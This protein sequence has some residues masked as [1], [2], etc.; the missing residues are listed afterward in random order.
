MLEGDKPLGLA[1][2]IALL[3][4]VRRVCPAAEVIDTSAARDENG[5][6]LSTV[7]LDLTIQSRNE[8]ARST[9]TPCFSIMS[10]KPQQI[11]R[12]A[13]KIIG[14]APVLSNSTP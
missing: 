10:S 13:Q 2:E 4:F 12:F 14:S 6:R 5:R 9:G 3:M 1:S 11:P 7:L 8:C